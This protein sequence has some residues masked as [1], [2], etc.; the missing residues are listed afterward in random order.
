[1]FDGVLLRAFFLQN[2]VL[3]G[4]ETPEVTILQ[5]SMLP[6]EEWLPVVQL[7]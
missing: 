1:V 5:N 6:R 2:P 4:V 3:L 7:V